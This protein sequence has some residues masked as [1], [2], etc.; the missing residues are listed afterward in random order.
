VFNL[1]TNAHYCVLNSL[2][3]VPTTI[4]TNNDYLFSGHEDGKVKL[5]DLRAPGKPSIVFNGHDN[6]VSDIKIS[7]L[8]TQLF[9]SISYDK[10]VKFFDVRASKPLWK[11]TADCDKN[12]GLEFNS[13][14]YLLVG[15]ESSNVNIYEISF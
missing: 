11:M 12:F 15:G 6:Y 9:A 1:N 10:S 8:S 2:Y 7:P 13:S 3:S 5:W 4:T 14:K